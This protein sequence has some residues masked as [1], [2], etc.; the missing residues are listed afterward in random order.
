MVIAAA[1]SSS[2]LVDM[3]EFLSSEE[4]GV[5]K[6]RGVTGTKRNLEEPHPLLAPPAPK[7]LPP[8]LQLGSGIPV[9]INTRIVF[10]RGGERERRRRG[11]LPPLFIAPKTTY[12]IFSLVVVFFLLSFPIFGYLCE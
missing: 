10:R 8:P 12:H 2:T 6:C 11:G 1:P 7:G 5:S 4:C 3:M 9:H